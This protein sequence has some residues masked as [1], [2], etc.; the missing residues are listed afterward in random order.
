MDSSL[1]KGVKNQLFRELSDEVDVVIKD[2][3][4]YC[5]ASKFSSSRIKWQKFCDGIGDVFGSF[6]LARYDGGSKRKPF[7]CLATF[8]NEN[9]QFN[10]WN[11]N[12][13]SSMLIYFGQNPLWIETLSLGFSISEHAIQRVFERS[14]NEDLVLK[15]ELK[16]VLFSYDLIYAPLWSA[17]WTMVAF[18]SFESAQV[19]HIKIIIPGQ[20]GLFLGD[21]HES[22]PLRCEIRTFVAKSQLGKRQLE[23]MVMMTEISLKYSDSIIP[24]ILNPKL[25]QQQIYRQQIDEFIA[26]A[27]GVIKLVNEEYSGSN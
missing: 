24:F 5:E 10:S 9:R 6:L 13:I 15:K 7:L 2:Y 3:L 27:Q 16:R 25:I 14:Y 1:A 18:K 23:L 4:K 11:E 22:K 20:H 26:Q 21:V 8:E 12:C 19:T 17:F